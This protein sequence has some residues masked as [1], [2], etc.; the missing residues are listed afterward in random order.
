MILTASAVQTYALQAY[1]PA[2]VNGQS[3]ALL[4]KWLGYIPTAN[5]ND[6]AQYIKNPGSE[7]YTQSG[8]PGQLA[9]QIDSSYPL[10]GADA[11]STSNTPSNS[12]SSGTSAATKRRDAIIGVSVG[13]GG[14]LWMILIYWIYRRVKQKHDENLHKRLSE[15]YS[16]YGVGAAA[17]G[18][19][20][21]G[22][23]S[24]TSSLA[25]SEVDGR[26][27][28]FYANPDENEPSMRERRHT[29]ATNPSGRSQYSDHSSGREAQ[30]SP[31]P[32][33]S[34]WFRSSVGSQNMLAS[35][36]P[37]VPENPFADIVHRSYLD[38]GPDPRV[39]GWRRSPQ[40]PAGGK[41]INKRLIGN[42]TLQANSLEFTE[43]GMR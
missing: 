8:I 14:V 35:R 3:T 18:H 20:P 37:H 39:N 41:P 31:R 22:R 33:G 42:P 32:I 13:V 21:G 15:R 28:S 43:H 16:Q 40:G 25:A 27:S 11:T 26:P 36:P 30:D 7:I 23:H 2:A 34:T 4:T 6:L 29:H 24:R 17:G 12:A 38:H 1:S 9:A 5:V 10:V 19:V